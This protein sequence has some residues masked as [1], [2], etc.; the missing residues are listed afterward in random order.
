MVDLATLKGLHPRLAAV[1]S[2]Y[3]FHENQF[4]YPLNDNQVASVEPMM[5]QLYGALAADQLLF[6]SNFNRD[7]FLQGVADLLQR[8]PDNVPHG[9]SDRLSAKCAVLPLMI[10]AIDN[11]LTGDAQIKN[12]KLILW[13]HRWEYDKAPQIFSDALVK[14]KHRGVEF[15]LAL[16]GPRPAKKPACLL[17]IE[18]N[19]NGCII[20]NG[21]LPRDEYIDYVS[22]ASIV[23]STAI[24]EYQGLSVMEA[25]SAG[26]VPLVP[27]ALCYREQYPEEYRYQQG[28]SDA[29]SER[30]HDYLMKLPESPDVSYWS[31][32]TLL[33]SWQQKIL[34]S[35]C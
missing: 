11:Q 14:L 34:G 7:S 24:H 23:V 31:S 16:L 12:S 15:E 3:Y 1:P 2:L 8:F 32:E 4:A 29:L 17:E 30:L 35:L 20:A 21:R 28:D 5:V 33:E 27:D 22:R 13:N 26:A 10:D 25:V 19:L 6:N 9:I 18:Q